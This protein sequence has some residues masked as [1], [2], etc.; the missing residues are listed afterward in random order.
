[1]VARGWAAPKKAPYTHLRSLK[2]GPLP[3]VPAPPQLEV[4]RA[5]VALVPRQVAVQEQALERVHRV[6]DPEPHLSHLLEHEVAEEPRDVQEA[7]Q[8]QA[9][10]AR[11]RLP[12]TVHTL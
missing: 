9:K 1:M 3:E 6:V 12:E 11:P 7:V 2:T 5:W 8:F 10:A 4:P